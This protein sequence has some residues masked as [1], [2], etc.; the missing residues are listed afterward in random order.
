MNTDNRI[1]ASAVRLA[2]EPI[3]GAWVSGRQQGFI[4]G[5]S[6]LSNVAEIEHQAAFHA[7]Q[8]D[9]SAFILF[10]FAAAFPSIDQD[11]LFRTLEHVGLPTG[12]LNL[13]R[14]STITMTV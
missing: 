6:M 4:K 3:L 9:K 1:I 11:F 5:R 13:V 2:L 12:I 8:E 14:A 7:L 10:D